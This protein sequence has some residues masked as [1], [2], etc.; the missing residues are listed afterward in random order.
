MIDKPTPPQKWPKWKL[1]GCVS[2]ISLFLVVVAFKLLATVIISSAVWE[3]M[4]DWSQDSEPWIETSFELPNNKGLLVLLLQQAHPFLAE[5]NRKLRLETPHQEPTTLNLPINT[6]WQELTNVYLHT[7][8]SANQTEIT[9]IHLQD[10]HS[11]YY[12]DINNAKFLDKELIISL[13]E[14]IYLGRFDGRN[15]PLQFISANISPEEPVNQ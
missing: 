10:R 15:W 7:V 8:S 9:V 4:D 12:L 13:S 2:I 6:G 1:I 11:D 14:G 3:P 5:Y